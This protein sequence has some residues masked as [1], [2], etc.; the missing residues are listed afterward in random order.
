MSRRAMIAAALSA[1]VLVVAVTASVEWQMCR[2]TFGPTELALFLMVGGVFVAAGL[3]AGCYRPADTL[4]RLLVAAGLLWLVKGFRLSTVPALFTAGT[5]LTNMYIPVLI[6]LVFSFPWGRLHH[7][8]ERRFIGGC[9]GYY[10]VSVICELAFLDTRRVNSAHPPGLNLLLVRDDPTIFA[11]MQVVFGVGGMAI[12]LVLIGVLL[13]RWRSGTRAY[14][15]AVAPLCCA[16][17]LGTAATAWT[18]LASVWVHSPQQAWTLLLRYPSTALIPLA[19][20]VGLWRYRVTRAAVR[21][22]SVDIGAT[23]FG[24]GF[25]DALREALRDPSL[26]LW[27]YSRVHDGY[28]DAQGLRQVLPR[29]NDAREATALIHE[30]VLM[31]A[32]VYDKAV[33]DQPRLLAAVRTATTRALDTRRQRGG[34]CAERHGTRSGG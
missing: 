19:V 16:A 34:P 2:T 18:P 33:A 26:A 15:A 32:L 10:A 9:Y 24:E 8:W 17:L 13:A 1:A 6:Q 4:G 28:V 3:V 20:L 29:R 7:R 14:R 27:S 31:G 30:G 5:V 22:L 12:G 11:A 25:V 21:N 23:P